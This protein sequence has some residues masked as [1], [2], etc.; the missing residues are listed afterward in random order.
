MNLHIFVPLKFY[1][2]DLD[3]AIAV[4]IGVSVTML[5]VGAVISYFALQHI[6]SKI[7]ALAKEMVTNPFGVDKQYFSS[8][9]NN[10][11]GGSDNN[12]EDSSSK[13][14]QQ[15]ERSKNN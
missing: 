11:L 8:S 1:T 6:T 3:K 9:N 7:S 15:K 14:E 4:A 10:S 13:E 2:Q 12:S 5:V